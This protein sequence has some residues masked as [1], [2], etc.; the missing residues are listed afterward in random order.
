[1]SWIEQKYIGIV[2]SRFRNFRRKSA[3]LWNFSCPIC[4]DSET[5]KSRARG[6]IYAR[7]GKLIYHCHNC[8][9]T[10]SFH[11]FLK[12]QDPNLYNE[13]VKESLVEQGLHKP[14]EV[15]LFAEKMKPPVFIKANTHLAK[16]KKISSLSAD[17]PA[18]KYVVSRNI[19]TNL[20]A[21]LFYCS[22]FKAWVNTIIPDKFEDISIDEPRLIIPFLNKEDQLIGFQGR[23]FKS[24]DALRYITIMVDESQPRLYGLDSVDLSQRVY[25]LEGPIDSMFIPNAI[26]SAGGNIIRELDQLGLDKNSVTVVY[27]NEPRNIDTIHKI[28]KAIDAGYDV[29]IWPDSVTEKDINDMINVKCKPGDYVP[30]ERIHNASKKIVS[31]ID[32]NTHRGLE[33]KLVLQLWKK[34]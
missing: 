13:Y 21:K 1:M 32:S 31:V 17:H 18:K 19:P 10:M 20:H 7:K 8:D 25:V 9:I 27:D 2:G 22:K 5:I 33:A 26:A 30:T 23:S 24:S 28:E 34:V 29:C 14:S 4:G 16:I 11:K 12:S 15:Q 3:N 6:Y